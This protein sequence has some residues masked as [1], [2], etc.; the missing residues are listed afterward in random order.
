MVELEGQGTALK[1][2]RDVTSVDEYLEGIPEEA[3]AALEK[4]RNVIKV[5]A[6]K[7]TEAISYQIPTF[8]HHECS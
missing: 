3:R 8:K 6:P 2:G 4:L 1:P 5:A 7:A